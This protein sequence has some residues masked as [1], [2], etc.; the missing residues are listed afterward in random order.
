MKTSFLQEKRADSCQLLA[1]YM[2]TF[3]LNSK[4]AFA[5]YKKNCEERK[6]PRSCYKL[7]MYILAGKGKEN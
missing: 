6:W 5:L 1:E 7:A 2:E 4:G 3:E